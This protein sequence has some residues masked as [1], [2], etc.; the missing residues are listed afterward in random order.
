LS[1][2]V[3]AA[4]IGSLTPTGASLLAYVSARAAR[5]ESGRNNLTGLAATVETQRQAVQ[6]IE[7]VTGRIESALTGVRERIAHLEGRLD[8]RPA[9]LP[10]DIAR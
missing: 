4:A 9:T 3:L 2:A 10:R 8:G 5:R 6:R 7:A 1:D